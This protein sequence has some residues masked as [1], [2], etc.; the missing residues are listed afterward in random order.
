MKKLTKY[1]NFKTLKS[2]N[3]AP[4]RDDKAASEFDTFLKLLQKEYSN[5]KKIK[6]TNGKQS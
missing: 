3:P 4:S 6:S 5:K 2:N 1:N